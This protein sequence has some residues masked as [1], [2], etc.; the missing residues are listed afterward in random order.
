[1]RE[2]R[3]SDGAKRT[4]ECTTPARALGRAGAVLALALLLG[5]CYVVRQG[6]EQAALLLRQE[7]FERALADPAFPEAAKEKLRLLPAIKAYGERELGLVATRSYERLVRLDR[8]ALSYVVVASP[9]L[10]LEAKTWSF[11]ILGAVPYKGYFDR[12]EAEAEAQGLRAEGFDALVRNVPAFSTLGWLPDPVYAPMLE[13]STA[14]FVNVI[15]HETTH[16]T[17]YLSGQGDFNE[18]FASYVGDHG[19]LGFCR[20]RFGPDSPE[21]KRA[22]ARLNGGKAFAAWIDRLGSDLEALYAS[23]LPEAEKRARKAR[24]FEAARREATE[25]GWRVPERDFNNAWVVSNR[26]YQAAR[27]VFEAAHPRAGGDVKAVVAAV[28]AVAPGAKDPLAAVAA[29]FGVPTPSP[30]SSAPLP[31]AR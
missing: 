15:L 21:V 9:A 17:L 13:T 23:A 7:P 3:A 1:M 25:A 27:P 12:K 22:E 16:A 24:R 29:R 5:G 6:T 4:Q 14:D 26:T 2:L 31:P 18:A 19:A 28:R 10:A 30:S 8:D 11:P 20:S